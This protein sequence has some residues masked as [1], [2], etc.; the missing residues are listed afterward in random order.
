ME[1]F[2]HVL[3]LAEFWGKRISL[4]ILTTGKWVGK[5]QKHFSTPVLKSAF[6]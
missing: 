4:G 6:I 5:I 1:V 3:L 2:D